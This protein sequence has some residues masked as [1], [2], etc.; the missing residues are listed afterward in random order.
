MLGKSRKKLLQNENGFS[1]PELMVVLLVGAIILVLALPQIISSRRLMK[2]SAMQKQFASTLAEARQEAMSQR[3]VVTFRYD[4]LIKRITIHGGSFGA[5]GDAA[6]KTVD[7]TGN[8]VEASEI[9]YGRPSGVPTNALG[10]TTN[11]TALSLNL[12]NVTFQP[13]GSVLDASSNPENKAFFFYHNKYPTDTAFAVSVLG[14]GGRVK[15]W[16]YKQDV[17]AYVE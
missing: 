12:V 11:L 9:I 14:A 7:F 15:V 8:G 3:R 17:N 16:R 5:F 13:D 4:D 6:N 2:F 10:D 1:I